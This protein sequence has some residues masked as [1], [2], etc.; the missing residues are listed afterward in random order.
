MLRYAFTS[1]TGMIQ[2]LRQNKIFVSIQNA[3]EK[4]HTHTQNKYVPSSLD[5]RIVLRSLGMQAIPTFPCKAAPPP[6]KN[7]NQ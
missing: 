7:G 5:T 4:T 3:H 2:R 6:P 1:S